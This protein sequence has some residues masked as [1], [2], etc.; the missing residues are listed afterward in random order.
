MNLDI[1]K[2]KD[3]IVHAPLYLWVPVVVLGLVLVLAGVRLIWFGRA[4]LV[5]VVASQPA[6][7]PPASVLPAKVT[8]APQANAQVKPA[9]SVSVANPSPGATP[10]PSAL[11]V[12]PPTPGVAKP[13]ALMPMKAVYLLDA[14][15]APAVGAQP[16][17]TAIGHKLIDTRVAKFQTLN[18]KDLG[19]LIPSSGLLRE[20]W[21][22]WVL[23]ASDGEFATV[24][25][26]GG[27]YQTE[28]S[29]QVDGRDVPALNAHPGN[30]TTNSIASLRLG[31]GWHQ[32][33][34]QF[35]QSISSDRD[36]MH[37]TAELFWR[38]PGDSQPVA[39]TPNAIDDVAKASAA[40]ASV[41]TAST[42]G[43][44]K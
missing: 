7:T 11:M 23:A 13:D 10:I 24:L 39:I 17:W 44:A 27:Y 20:S 41:A 42:A 3:R 31:I 40:S 43:G 30:T 36:L 21:S 19:A 37:G 12:E 5:P 22:F 9:V 2:I 18:E 1:E 6:P 26:A 29:V 8:A 38:G 14:A 25:K 15:P 35:V 33:T 4:P 16:A 28:V 32:V 34:I